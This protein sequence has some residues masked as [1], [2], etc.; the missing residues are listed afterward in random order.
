MDSVLTAVVNESVPDVVF[1]NPVLFA[2]FVA[3]V[4]ESNQ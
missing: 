3:R 4:D 2:L 1:F